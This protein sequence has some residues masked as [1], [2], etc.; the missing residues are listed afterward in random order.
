MTPEQEAEAIRIEL[1]LR[2]RSATAEQPAAPTPTAQ[3]ATPSPSMALG[4]QSGNWDEP[5]T[6]ADALM[7]I[8]WDNLGAVERLELYARLTPKH[9]KQ[10]LLGIG[11]QTGGFAA[12]AAGPAIGQ[13]IGRATR[14][15][16]LDRILG[17]AGGAIGE[18]AGQ[19]IENEPFSPGKILGA[20]FTG[21]TKG[22]PLAGA[23]GRE[24]GFEGAKD[25]IVNVTAKTIE[26]G[27]T[28]GRLPTAG[29]TGAAMAGGAVAAV[30]GKAI[31]SGSAAAS[32]FARGGKYAPAE[33]VVADARKRGYVFPPSKMGGRSL[34]VADAADFLGGASPNSSALANVA[35]LRNQEVTDDLARAYIKAPKG[36]P[37]DEENLAVL[38]HAA[39]EPYRKVAAVSPQAA[40]S[41]EM[42]RQAKSDAK[43]AW[44]RYDREPSPEIRKFAEENDQ[45]ADL[46]FDDM[47]VEAN[48]ARKPHLIPEL[49]K[50]R[51]ELAK[52]HLVDR[53]MNYGD[54]HVSAKT[55]SSAFERGAPLT[56][57]ADLI[58]RMNLAF[59]GITRDASTVTTTGSG[60][61]PLIGAAVRAITLSRPGQ[62]ALLGGP[63]QD[64]AATAARAGVMSETR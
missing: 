58:A 37:L 25:A 47:I 64:A 49:E 48:A 28:E 6:T 57:E 61:L 9:A 34:G 36:M 33:Q 26:T 11:K 10:E 13:T 53:S 54:F 50:G 22:K 32:G 43:K 30:A 52:L 14:I 3:T 35:V 45:L 7:R 19:Q 56:D 44:R 24:V 2:S 41:L 15:P 42:F 18:F 40:A 63:A 21:G 29:E 46:A 16:L 5:I 1:E 17:A 4:D 55:F 60:K 59:P 62:N 31:D 12:R 39:E 8:G 23:S 38:F 20:A 51:V 27:V